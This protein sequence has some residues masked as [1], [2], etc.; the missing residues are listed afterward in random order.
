MIN[1]N[2]FNLYSK[3]ILV[4]YNNEGL[5]NSDTIVEI[6]KSKGKTSLYKY[7]YKKFRDQQI[8]QGRIAQR[9]GMLQQAVGLNQQANNFDA[10]K[11]V[12]LARLIFKQARALKVP[13]RGRMPEDIDQIAPL[14]GFLQQVAQNAPSD[15]VRTLA[16]GTKA[17]F[18]NL[19][20]INEDG[21]FFLNNGIPINNA[22]N[23]NDAL[24]KKI[25]LPDGRFIDAIYDYKKINIDKHFRGRA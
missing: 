12:A 3:F 21:S 14:S 16:A 25:R 1:L 18:D 8:E 5:M 9:E 13:I 2:I 15:Y 10:G 17:L 24:R 23:P 19:S 20:N 4:S 7:E 22:F 11:R 6:L